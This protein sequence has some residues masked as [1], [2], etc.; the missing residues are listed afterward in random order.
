MQSGPHG[1]G[2]REGSE[3]DLGSHP[4]KERDFFVLC[5]RPK[6]GNNATGFFVAAAFFN[7]TAG[8]MRRAL[9]VVASVSERNCVCACV[10]VLFK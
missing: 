4:W 10:F 1:G 5:V 2:G 7:Q 3:V 9:Q 6:S 8:S